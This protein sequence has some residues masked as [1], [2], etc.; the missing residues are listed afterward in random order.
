[1]PLI[2]IIF[3]SDELN[4]KLKKNENQKKMN[5]TENRCKVILSVFLL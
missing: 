1:M 2:I 3:T 4:E 5:Q